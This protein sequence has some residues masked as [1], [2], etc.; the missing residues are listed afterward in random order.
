MYDSDDELRLFPSKKKMLL[1]IAGSSLFTIGGISGLGSGD[2]TPWLCTIFFGLCALVGIVNILPNASYLH[3]TPDGFEVKSLY[4]LRS[5][6][7]SDVH[8]FRVYDVS[9]ISKLVGFDL[10]DSHPANKTARK[11]SS[12][13]AGVEDSLPDNY[14]MKAEAL[15]RMMNEWKAHAVHGS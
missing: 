11:I 3:L 8:D 15:A 5:Y 1:L 4:K 6:A 7:W 13:V 2:V 9:D 14:G 12:T 10:S